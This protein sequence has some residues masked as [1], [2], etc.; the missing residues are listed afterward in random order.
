MGA[1]LVRKNDFSVLL[2][3]PG[4]STGE[5]T[6]TLAERLEDR[7]L[8]V[9]PAQSQQ[10]LRRSLAASAGIGAALLDWNLFASELEFHATLDDIQRLAERPPVVLLADQA[11]ECGL[12]PAVAERADG[13]FWLQ[14]DSP[15]FV[16]RQVEQLVE[17]YAEKLMTAFL[18]ELTGYR[19]E[20]DW[21]TYR[22]GPGGHLVATVTG[23]S[24]PLLP[25]GGV[26][27]GC[28]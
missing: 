8:S 5:A 14:A 21:T 4:L 3:Q 11:D 23:P 2:A 25:P 27:P 26:A 13:F 17:R 28:R 9:I 1:R 10:D 19:G 6:W 16:A 20:P 15:S 12:P 18:A 22:P 24:C 7:G